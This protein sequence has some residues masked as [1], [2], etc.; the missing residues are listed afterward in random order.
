MVGGVSGAGSPLAPRK[1]V[2]HAGPVRARADRHPKSAAQLPFIQR[3]RLT[4]FAYCREPCAGQARCTEAWSSSPRRPSGDLCSKL[5]LHGRGIESSKV[6]IREALIGQPV[7]ARQ[8]ARQQFELALLD[9]SKG[10]VAAIA[11]D[12]HCRGRLSAVA[13]VA[14][15]LK[16]PPGHHVGHDRRGHECSVASEN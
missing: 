9:Y 1:P 3:G 5:R 16:C 6:R 7:L 14:G 15:A 10:D 12:E 13:G 11:R 8:H 4:A 2:Q